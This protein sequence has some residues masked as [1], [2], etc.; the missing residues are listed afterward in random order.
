MKKLKNFYIN[1]FYSIVEILLVFFIIS[2][3]YY[4][5]LFQGETYSFFLFLSLFIIF[6]INSFQVGRKGKKKGYLIGIRFGLLFD[7]LFLI[8]TISLKRFE[9]SCL[10]YYFLVL[11]TTTLGAAFG[12]LSKKNT[13][14]SQ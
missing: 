4:F 13:E 10:F 14:L 2:V 11:C 12:A 3:F 1:I 6:L 8:L 5:S 9:I 7:T